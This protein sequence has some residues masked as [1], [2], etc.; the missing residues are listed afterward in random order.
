MQGH[1]GP[2]DNFVLRYFPTI[3][4]Q[5][6]GPE[7]RY[8]DPKESYVEVIN[9]LLDVVFNKADCS[10]EA[11]DPFERS[12]VEDLRNLVRNEGFPVEELPSM[13]DSFWRL[14]FL[15]LWLSTEPDLRRRTLFTIQNQVEIVKY[16][17]R[18]D[19]ISPGNDAVVEAQC[20]R[21]LDPSAENPFDLNHTVP[22]G[23]ATQFIQSAFPQLFVT[24]S[25][26][27]R[28]FNIHEDISLD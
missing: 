13:F 7:Y 28:H 4:T 3:A 23:I 10:F 20:N 14:G 21:M 2:R 9:E 24:S 17:L 15:R 16:V 8:H 5:G 11:M 19:D 12:L 22:S 26:D 6:G 18:Q 27:S 1:P 25:M